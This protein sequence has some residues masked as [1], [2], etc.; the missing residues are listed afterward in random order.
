MSFYLIPS[1]FPEPSQAYSVKPEAPIRRTVMDTGRSRQRLR[2]SKR[3]RQVSV[4][5]ELTD[6]ELNWFNGFYKFGTRSGELPFLL[7]LPFGGTGCQRVQ[8]SFVGDYKVSMRGSFHWTVSAR[9]EVET[10]V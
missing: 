3:I 9:L 5:W 4:Q 7:D 1:F 10:I 8:A 2:W 6:A